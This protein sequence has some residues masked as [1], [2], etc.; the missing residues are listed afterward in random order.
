MTELKKRE[1]TNTGTEYTVQSHFVDKNTFDTKQQDAHRRLLTHP[2]TR[3]T[4][5]CLT[6]YAPGDYRDSV[7]CAQN[8]VHLL[9]IFVFYVVC[10][11]FVSFLHFLTTE[12]Q[13]Y[14]PAQT[15]SHR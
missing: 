1:R 4:A 12:A 9:F 13:G 10:A 2:G 11:I 3:S 6:C 14:P 5:P 7:W 15:Y 8:V